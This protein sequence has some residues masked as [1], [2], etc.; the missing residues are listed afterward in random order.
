MKT[1]LQFLH[2]E[3]CITLNIGGQ[4]F[5]TTVGILTRDPFSILAACCRQKALFRSCEEGHAIFFDR[6]WWIFRHI[7][8]YLRSNTLPNELETLKELYKEASF[9][10]L[11]SLQRAI[12]EVPISQISNLTTHINFDTKA[13]YGTRERTHLQKK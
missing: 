6:D 5:E 11:L 9:Y 2:P 3:L 12:E 8:S 13:G 10:R 7:L 1:E 4:Y